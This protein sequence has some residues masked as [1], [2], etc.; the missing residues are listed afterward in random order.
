MEDVERLTVQDASRLLGISEGAVRKRVARGTLEHERDAEGKVW[1][2][3]D[4]GTRGRTRAGHDQDD[5]VPDEQDAGETR[6]ELVVELRDRISYLERQ[7]EEEREARRRADTLMARFLE[8][9]PELEA[10]RDAHGEDTDQDS[11]QDVG[12]TRVPAE[13][14]AAGRD[15][16]FSRTSQR[17]QDVSAIL[18]VVFGALPAWVATLKGQPKRSSLYGVC[19][20]KRTSAW[21]WESARRRKSVALT[22]DQHLLK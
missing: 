8:R 13:Q 9:V 11:G 14:D 2:L 12:E 19:G 17:L 7:V 22:W 3:L 1:V 16:R 15:K 6:D 5:R 10:P 20:S 21:P 18:G 4:A